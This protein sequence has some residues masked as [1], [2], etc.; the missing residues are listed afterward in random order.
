MKPLLNHC[1]LCKKETELMLSHIIPKFSYKYLKDTAAGKLRSTERPNITIQD[2]E[3]CYLLCRNCEA[4]FSTY[5]KK[6]AEKIFFPYKNNEYS[7]FGYDKWLYFFM[8]TVSWRILYIDL[9]DFVS[10]CIMG[11]DALQCLIEKEQIMR[12]YLLGNSTALGNIEHHI[13]F[14]EDVERWPKEWADKHPHT[15]IH[16]SICGY[17][18]ANEQTK[19]YYTFTNMLGVLLIT[20]YSKGPEEQSMRTQINEGAGFIEAKNQH[21]KSVIIQELDHITTLSEHSYHQLSDLQ[22]EKINERI[23]RASD[24]ISNYPIFDDQKKDETLN[25]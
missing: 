4:L 5:E 21:L 8:T 20:F 17:S 22:K 1:A 18:A 19:T 14:F 12:K 10:N 23:L 6:F 2:G 16:R 9:I 13:F 24:S 3:K 7:A 15:S 11:I 25:K